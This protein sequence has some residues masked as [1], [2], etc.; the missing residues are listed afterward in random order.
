MTLVSLMLF[1]VA[2]LPPSDDVR[3]LED[4][5]CR[6]ESEGD[7][8]DV[9]GGFSPFV[10]DIA[11]ARDLASRQRADGSW[12]DVDYV[13]DRRSGWPPAAHVLDRAVFLAREAFVTRDA[14]SAAAVRKALDWWAAAKP[15]CS[16]WWYNE[17]GVPQG[18]ALAALLVDGWLHDEDRTRYADYLECSQIRMTGQNRVWLSRIVMMRGILRRD[19]MLIGR[20]VEAILG[21]VRISDGEGIMDDW[22]FRQ[23]G[24]QMQFGNYGA[25]FIMTLSR[26]A[27]VLA[28][29]KWAMSGEQRRILGR[30]EED[31]FRWTLW[32]GRMDVAA[33][34][35]QIVPGAQE[36][37]CRAIERA[38]SEFAAGGWTFPE[39]QPRGF[40][41]FPRSAYAVWRTADWMASVKMHTHEILE[42]ETWVN[43]E[44]TLGGHLADGALYLYSTGREYD[45]VF[46]LWG[47]WRL[48]PG[49]TGYIDLPPVRRPGF[50]TYPGA[51]EADEMTASG[52][53]SAAQVDFTLRRDGLSVRKRWRFT[54]EG[55]ECTGEGISATNGASRV[56]TCV[57]HAFAA[58]N[59]AVMPYRDGRLTVR[60]G[61]FTYEIFAPEEAVHAAIEDRVGDWVGIAPPGAGNAVSAGRVLV[62]W[63]DHG[64]LPRDA[65]YR[66]RVTVSAVQPL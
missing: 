1:A 44:N 31:G 65:S 23:H 27:N 53:G 48:I 16:N 32:K 64:R 46:P 45:G 59:A 25:S 55:V 63:I 57:E 15:R 36:G 13:T 51:N 6:I 26:L 39:D 30:L 14:A 61:A 58:P 34:G 17:I 29:T 19:E 11:R 47:N 54:P 22:S 10:A 8:S 60:N 56:A 37:K 40:R 50:V 49:V 38:F 33:L 35:R 28:T 20:A 66:Y 5:L 42:T 21:E 2:V 52:D 9:M 4:R 24:P 62:I 18:F 12:P 3:A 41:F 7:A 43:G